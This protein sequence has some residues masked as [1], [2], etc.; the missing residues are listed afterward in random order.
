VDR[1]LRRA[2]SIDETIAAAQLAKKQ[3][4]DAPEEESTPVV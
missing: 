4:K 3:I 1:P 2:E